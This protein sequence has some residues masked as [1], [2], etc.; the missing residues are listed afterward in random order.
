MSH[1]IADP[2]SGETNVGCGQH[3][4]LGRHEQ[5][6][7]MM[8]RGGGFGRATRVDAPSSPVD[9]APTVLR[10]LGLPHDG[11]DGAPLSRE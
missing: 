5:Q 8:V 7:F 11:M 9:I 1:A 2:L 10:H 4:G 6:P 3:G